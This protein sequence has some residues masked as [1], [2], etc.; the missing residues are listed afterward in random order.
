MIT[1]DKMETAENI[2]EACALFNASTN[3]FRINDFDQNMILKKLY[4][5]DKYIETHVL[6][7]LTEDDETEND[8]D[9]MDE[10][11]SIWYSFDNKQLSINSE[12]DE[13][14]H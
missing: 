5:I 1:G 6:V 2:G 14:I 10:N 8:E 7:K 4:I 9:G 12:H 11:S 13:V 3:V